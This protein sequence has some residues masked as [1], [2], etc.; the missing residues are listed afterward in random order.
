MKQF[1]KLK[2]Q[3]EADHKPNFV[4]LFCYQKKDDDHSSWISVTRYLQRPTRKHGRA[5]LNT[6]LFGLAPSGVYIASPVARRTGALL[7][8]RFTLTLDKIDS[9]SRRAKAVY[10]LLHFP[11]RHHDSTL[12]STL[13]F[14]VRT[15]LPARLTHRAIIWSAPTCKR[16]HLMIFYQFLIDYLPILI[17]FFIVDHPMTLGAK[18]QGFSTLNFNKFLWGNIHKATTTCCICQR[19]DGNS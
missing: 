12:W 8:H 15:F 6:S 18:V 17:N 2:K 13:P 7:P 9:K 11:S 1:L 16:R 4:S 14:G 10:F 19:N 5:A 3:A